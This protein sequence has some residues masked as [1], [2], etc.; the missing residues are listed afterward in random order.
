MRKYVKYTLTRRK[1]SVKSH[2]TAQHSTAQH[3]TSYLFVFSD[4]NHLT[5]TDRN[6]KSR[7]A[8]GFNPQILR[9]DFLRSKIFQKEENT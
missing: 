3:S 5:L 1:F 8:G 2:S 9:G 7:H 6:S 4:R